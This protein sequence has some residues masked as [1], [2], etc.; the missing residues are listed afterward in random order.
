MQELSEFW[1]AT[2]PDAVNISRDFSPREFAAA[3][4][5]LKPGKVPGPDSICPR[6]FIPCWSRLEVLARW[7]PFF[8]LAL[9]QN[10]KSLEKGAGG[11]D[12]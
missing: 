8:L 4:H 3:L 11:H 9:T 6:A 7:L 10:F 12:L 1:R 2:T 5:H